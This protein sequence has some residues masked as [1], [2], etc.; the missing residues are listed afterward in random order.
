MVGRWVCMRNGIDD[1]FAS[2]PTAD[3]ALPPKPHRCTD[4]LAVMPGAPQL[5]ETIRRSTVARSW[6]SRSCETHPQ[7]IDFIQ[8][9]PVS[10]LRIRAFNNGDFLCP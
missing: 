5:A 9:R 7:S 3:P 2:L 1:P 4:T 10:A 6:A 8:T